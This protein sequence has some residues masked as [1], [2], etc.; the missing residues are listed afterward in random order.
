MRR[1]L[2]FV[3]VA[4]FVL[5]A[6]LSA[7]VW[8]F[9]N[10]KTYNLGSNPS[11]GTYALE[12]GLGFIQVDGH[13]EQD[14]ELGLTVLPGSVALESDSDA[15]FAECRVR[16][17]V[18]LLPGQLCALWGKS[19]TQRREYHIRISWVYEEKK[20]AQVVVV[21]VEKRTIKLAK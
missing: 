2:A 18:V 20:G 1:M 9:G 12:D 19:D 5:P 16:E 15:N 10:T 3:L 8:P 4:L 21:R 13:D 17:L 6:S 7:G 14:A 11:K